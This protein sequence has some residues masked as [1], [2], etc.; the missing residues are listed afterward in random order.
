MSSNDAGNFEN[1][2][3][4]LTQYLRGAAVDFDR[5]AF[6]YFAAAFLG[7]FYL[8]KNLLTGETC[9]FLEPRKNTRGNIWYGHT[10]RI[11]LI[12]ETLF[13]MRSS[14]GFAELCRRLGGRDFRSTYFEMYAAR[15][16]L[17][18]GYQI[19][20][21]PESGIKGQDFDFQAS[22]DDE[23]VNV[24]VTALTAKRFSA[25]TVENAL[26]QKRKQLPDTEPALIF[27]VFPEDWALTPNLGGL[28]NEPVA[29]FFQSTRKVGA[30]VFMV[31]TYVTDKDAPV[32]NFWM[33]HV[34]LFHPNPRKPVKSASF[35]AADAWINTRRSPGEPPTMRR[36]SEF[37]A[38]ADSIFL[39][40]DSVAQKTQG[41]RD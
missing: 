17:E 34:C 25:Q 19:R 39:S 28:L 35:F 14:P 11:V 27:C 3:S 12:G 40:R 6:Y 15:I 16:F 23:T 41:H 10:G 30:V 13:M 2:P 7:V 18:A 4:R 29:R 22:R 1:I 26:N 37:F 36:E 24:E 20:A 31:E 32:G 38:W 8:R 5:E 33:H 21:R 9:D